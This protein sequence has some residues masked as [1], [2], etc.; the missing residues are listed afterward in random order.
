MGGRFRSRSVAARLLWLASLVVPRAGRRRWLEEWESE[1]WHLEHA[2]GPPDNR[3]KYASLQGAPPRNR[4][5]NTQV[6]K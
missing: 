5:V 4:L 6:E 1:L 2:S 3:P